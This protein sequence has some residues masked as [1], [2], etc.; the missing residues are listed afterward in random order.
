MDH[1]SA[2]QTNAVERYLLGEMPNEERDSFEEHYFECRACADEIRLGSAM[3]RDLKAAL[4]QGLPARSWLDR[5][6]IPVLV[7]SFAAFSLLAV[8]GYQNL[9][10]LPDLKAPRTVGAAVILDPQTRAALPQVSAGDALRF[11][12]PLEAAAPA[13]RLKVEL[14]DASGQRRA[15][16]EVHAPPDHQPLDVLFPGSANPGRY[17][18]L[19]R[20]AADDKEVGRGSFQIVPAHATKEIPDR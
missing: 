15:Y 6:R 7:P 14:L 3:S 5:F 19:V 20:E 1:E 11:Q 8:V 13:D 10:L 16:G 9:V 18:V 2:I 17:V 4:R 12:L